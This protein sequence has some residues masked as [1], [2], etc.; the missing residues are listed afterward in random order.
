MGE[1][2]AAD[3]HELTDRCDRAAADIVADAATPMAAGPPNQATSAAVAQ[4]H[5]LVHSV[6]SEFARRLSAL[7]DAARQAARPATS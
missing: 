3:L 7:G 4:A 1:S 5:A 2:D 6:S